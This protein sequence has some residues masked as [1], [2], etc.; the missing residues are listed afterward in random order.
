MTLYVSL[1]EVSYKCS[2]ILEISSH[3]I[4]FSLQVRVYEVTDKDKTKL[5]WTVE[6]LIYI[7][8]QKFYI[9]MGCVVAVGK[10]S[11]LALLIR[12]QH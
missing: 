3:F 2:Q 1:N 6:A 12:I 11:G 4:D 7:S 5:S 10:I 9:V 8:S